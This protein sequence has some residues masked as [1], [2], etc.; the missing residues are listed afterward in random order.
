[1]GLNLD[2]KGYSVA[3]EDSGQNG[4]HIRNQGVIRV[5]S[6]FTK[7]ARTRLLDCDE[8]RRMRPYEKK[9]GSN[10]KRQI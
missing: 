4:K 6:T 2:E 10:W 7:I 8:L 1:M 9:P 3:A 5:V